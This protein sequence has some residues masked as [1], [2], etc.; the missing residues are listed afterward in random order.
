MSVSSVLLAE[1]VST[2]PNLHDFERSFL[3]HNS[4][5]SLP[6]R[7]GSLPPAPQFLETTG[8]LAEEVSTNENPHDFE[9]SFLDHN[10]QT[11]LPGR[12]GS[13]PRAPQ[14]PGLPIAREGGKC[15]AGQCS[16]GQQRAHAALLPDG[17]RF[18]QG[19]LLYTH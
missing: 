2:I 6:G 17:I 1:G 11:R 19:K 12:H 15:A 8:R 10:S 5:S 18:G 16:R 4:Q 9:R 13:I 7:H 3:D 14:P